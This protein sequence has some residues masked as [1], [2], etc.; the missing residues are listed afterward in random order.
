[1]KN[2][3]LNFKI[4][5]LFDGTFE[6]LFLWFGWTLKS[7]EKLMKIGKVPADVVQEKLKKQK[8]VV[9]TLFLAYLSLKIN[10]IFLYIVCGD[11]RNSNIVFVIDAV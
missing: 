11:E 5:Q 8:L 6:C 4:Y 3:Q 1:M 9:S 7:V 10:D 2:Y